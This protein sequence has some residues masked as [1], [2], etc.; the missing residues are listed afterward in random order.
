LLGFGK[1]G[2]AGTATALGG[3]WLAT[4]VAGRQFLARVSKLPTKLSIAQTNQLIV[5]L[6]TIQAGQQTANAIQPE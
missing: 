1:A 5:E 6:G 2:V 3:D 4:S